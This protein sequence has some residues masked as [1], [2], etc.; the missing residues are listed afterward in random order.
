MKPTEL[1]DIREEIKQARKRIVRL[2]AR[3][4]EP[5]SAEQLARSC[6]DL[7]NMCAVIQPNLE[8]LQQDETV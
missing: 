3:M 8:Y 4:I 1:E 2:A 6:A 7:R 5:C